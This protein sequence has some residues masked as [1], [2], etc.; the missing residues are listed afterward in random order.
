[1]N[2]LVQITNRYFN[3]GL[4]AVAVAVIAVGCSDVGFKSV[5][6][7][8]CDGISRDQNTTCL[9]SADSVTVSFSF[10]IG[11]V[12]VLFVD[13]NSGSMYVEQQKMAK[14]FP[15]FLNN[16][17]NLFYQIAIVTTDVSATP[18]NTVSRAAN[19]YGKFQDGKFLE[20]MDELKN[21]SG[22]KVIDRYTPNVQGLF[23]GTIK[24]QESLDC[25]TSGFNPELCPSSDE[26]GI[27]AANLAI[28]RGEANFFRPGAHLALVILSDEDERGNGGASG[29]VGPLEA[30]DFPESLV[31]NMKEIYP[32]KSMSVHSVVTNNETCRKAQT[33]SSTTS[34]WSTL[35]YIGTQYMKLSYPSADLMA[36]GNIITGVVGSICD[37]DSNY[38][39]QLGNIGLN[40]NNN[41]M[42][43]PRQLACLPANNSINIETDPAGLEGQIQYDIDNQNK[44]YF[45]NLPIGTRV[46]FSYD[47]PRY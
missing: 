46:T 23:R 25:D 21:P 2:M 13:D 38:G 16:I 42:D 43:A 7:L 28:K 10:G 19:G 32:T 40:I 26:R 39:A 11:E 22:L 15:N 8:S 20:F 24:R 6:K 37:S 9:N 31:L 34:M 5:P 1:M 33:Q 45:Y 3:Y 36:L 17:S 27:Y 47:C 14:A 41:T 12:D 18:G 44:I 30:L 35:G 4:A 29:S